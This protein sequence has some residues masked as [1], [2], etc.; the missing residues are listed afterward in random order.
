MISMC[1][2]LNTP[3]LKIPSRNNLCLGDCSNH[4]R[5]IRI[6]CTCAFHILMAR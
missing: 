5:P 6:Q 3:I 4:Y 1:T 2:G